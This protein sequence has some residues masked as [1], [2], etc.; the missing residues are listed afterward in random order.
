M[1]V[2]EGVNSRYR[3]NALFMSGYSIEHKLV[4]RRELLMPQYATTWNCAPEAKC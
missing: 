4:M 1:T 3:R 2:L